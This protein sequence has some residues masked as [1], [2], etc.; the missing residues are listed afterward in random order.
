MKE[1][2]TNLAKDADFVGEETGKEDTGYIAL[3]ES[4]EGPP[5][6]PPSCDCV[7]HQPCH[8]E[9]PCYSLKYEKV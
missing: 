8:G 6:L 2:L 1:Q 3:T 5:G 7:C 4:C 9:G